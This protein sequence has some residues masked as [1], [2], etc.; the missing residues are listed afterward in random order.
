MTTDTDDDTTR[1]SYEDAP[2]QEEIDGLIQLSG[3]IPGYH[4]P[5]CQVIVAGAGRLGM[6]AGEITHLK[7]DWIDWHRQQITIPSY[8]PC[9]CGYCRKA[10]EGVA[11]RN[12]DIEFESAFAQRWHPKS[13]AGART[14]PFG[15]D[16][17][18]YEVL[19]SY[20]SEYD[21][22]GHSRTSINRRVDRVCELA[23]IPKPDLY[24]HALRASAATWHA[25]KGLG[26]FPLMAFMGWKNPQTALKYVRLSGGATEQR[27]NEIHGSTGGEPA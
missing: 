26:Q 9:D 14:I 21:E 7:E 20:F 24:P 27:L 6:R 13:D 18:T 2:S 22:Y 19:E 25:Y 10:A 16:D 23:G 8:E 12:D 17:Q 15:F 11:T 1:H 3:T 4:G 5:E